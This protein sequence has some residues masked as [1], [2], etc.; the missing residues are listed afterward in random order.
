[1]PSAHKDTRTV[2]N[3]IAPRGIRL[4]DP[5][6]RQPKTAKAFNLFF[7]DYSMTLFYHQIY[8]A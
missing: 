7:H 6:S 3:M 8:V 1:M 5:I 2:G 4:C